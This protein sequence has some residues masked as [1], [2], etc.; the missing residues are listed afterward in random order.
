MGERLSIGD[1]AKTTVTKVVTIGYYEQAGTTIHGRAGSHRQQTGAR[2][3][4]TPA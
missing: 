1:L 2:D 3:R 4:G